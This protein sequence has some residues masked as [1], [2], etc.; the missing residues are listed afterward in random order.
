MARP[1][2]A[3]PTADAPPSLVIFLGFVDIREITGLL[4]GLF[5]LCPHMIQLR[6]IEHDLDCVVPAQIVMLIEDSANLFS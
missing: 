3:A 5:L 4:L 6:F 1:R 2:E